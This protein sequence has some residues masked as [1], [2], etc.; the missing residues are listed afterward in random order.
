MQELVQILKIVAGEIKE[1][2][3]CD[4][5]GE[6]STCKITFLMNNY[7]NNP[8]SKGYGRDDCSWCS[9][10]FAHACPVCQDKIRQNPPS[11]HVWVSIFDGKR[12]PHMIERS[13]KPDMDKVKELIKKYENS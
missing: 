7:R 9:D 10:A 13:V 8:A 11:G 1:P 12:F 4:E 6:D 3:P 5:C 2:I